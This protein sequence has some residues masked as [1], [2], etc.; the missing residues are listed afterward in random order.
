MEMKYINKYLF[1]IEPKEYAFSKTITLLRFPLAVFILLLHASFE[2]EL[3]NG[4]SIFD[5]WDAPI[6]HHLDFLFVQ[7]ICNIAVPLFFLISGFLFFFKDDSFTLEKYTSKLRKRFTSLLIPYFLWNVLVFIL[8]FVVQNV[9]PSMNSGRNKLISDYTVQDYFMSFWSMSYINEGGVSGPIDSPLWFI[10]DLM[11]MMVI[12]PVFYFIIRRMNFFLPILLAVAYIAGV[13]TGIQGISMVAL[14]FFSMGACFG[15]MKLDFVKFSRSI[16][17]YTC[18]L[19]LLLLM[20]ICML[21]EYQSPSAWCSRL[22]VFIGV[23]MAVGFASFLESKYSCHINPFLTSSTFF[24]FASHSEILKITIRL[25]SRL[26]VNSD[27]F[28]C[29]AYFMCP[30]VTMVV[31]LTVYWILLQKMPKVA[32]MLSGGR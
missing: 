2:H 22:A 19:Y 17:G 1:N 10:R 16:L 32:S 20:T 3:R 28:Y 25:T 7:N 21:A 6:Y 27:L 9:A 23:F 18:F 5:G 29:I 13:E 11:V 31:L 30:L 24:I 15:I 8:Y 26:G 14:A 4:V 12:S